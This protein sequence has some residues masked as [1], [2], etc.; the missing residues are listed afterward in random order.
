MTPPAVPGPPP[1][2]GGLAATADPVLGFLTDD[3]L[4][5]VYDRLEAIEAHHDACCGFQRDVCRY[6]LDYERLNDLLELAGAPGHLTPFADRAAFEAW[7]I[8][9]PRPAPPPVQ[10]GP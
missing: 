3:A 2:D 6:D 10:E 9:R 8:G 4:R 7:L 5:A 1:L